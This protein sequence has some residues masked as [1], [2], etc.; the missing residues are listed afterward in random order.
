MEDLKCLEQFY[1]CNQC[2]EIH[3]SYIKKVKDLNNDIYYETYCPKCQEVV[4]HLWVGQDEGEISYY[5]DVTLDKRY[6]WQN[7][8]I[9]EKILKGE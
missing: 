7:K 4:K 2:G 6:Y 9:N 8:M 5:Y 1:Q 3:R